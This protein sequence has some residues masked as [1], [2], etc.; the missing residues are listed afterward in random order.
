MIRY[1]VINGISEGLR[2][3]GICCDAPVVG[4]GDPWGFQRPMR[5]AQAF[6]LE[7]QV[8]GK[9][10]SGL[11]FKK[12]CYWKKFVGSLR[13]FQVSWKMLW[14]SYSGSQGS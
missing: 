10:A 2:H 7:F 4:P 9:M 12:Q 14:S 13:G 6:L 1:A 8:P 3:P 11:F 5:D